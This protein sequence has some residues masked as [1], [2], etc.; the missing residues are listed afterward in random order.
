MKRKNNIL[1]QL[2][3]TGTAKFNCWYSLSRYHSN[4]IYHKEKEPLHQQI[5]FQVPKNKKY[6]SQDILQ[7]HLIKTKTMC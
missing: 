3:K 5:N 2:P 1:N 6:I 7:I 4:E